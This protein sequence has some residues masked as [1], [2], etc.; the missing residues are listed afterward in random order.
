MS[1]I[2]NDFA[3]D[4]TSHDSHGD[5]RER[6]ETAPPD[7]RGTRE[8]TESIEK[9]G[10]P[11]SVSSQDLAQVRT[12]TYAYLQHTTHTHTHTHTHGEVV[13][14]SSTIHN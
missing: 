8:R 2:T 1:V 3:T 13:S 14:I 5:V 9:E 4:E 6:S 11:C 12:A 7:T 10:S